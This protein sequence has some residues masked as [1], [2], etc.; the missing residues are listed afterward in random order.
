MF[1][2]RQICVA[3]VVYAP[4]AALLSASEGEGWVTWGRILAWGV[5]FAQMA[6]IAPWLVRR[7][8]D[9]DF[10]MYLDRGEQ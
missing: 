9:E 2:L 4:L 3:V 6:A 8:R 10:E 7:R 5:L 1:S